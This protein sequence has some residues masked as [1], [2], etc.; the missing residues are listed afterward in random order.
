M[1]GTHVIPLAVVAAILAWPASTTLLGSTVS[2]PADDPVASLASTDARAPAICR[3]L[4]RQGVAVVGW[5]PGDHRPPWL[6][7]RRRHSHRPA[8]ARRARVLDGPPLRIGEAV[9]VSRPWRS[10]RTQLTVVAAAGSLLGYARYR[11]PARSGVSGTLRVL[12]RNGRPSPSLTVGG[13]R[14]PPVVRRWAREPAA[15]PTPAPTPTAT[16]TPVPTPTPPPAASG[17]SVVTECDTT[18][19]SDASDAAQF[20]RLWHDERNGPGWTGGD[21]AFSVRLDDGRIAWIFGDSFIG[22]VQPDGRRSPDWHLVRNTLVVQDGGCL[23]TAIGGT[24]QTPTALIRPSDP[25][26]W[27]WP[28]T[29]TAD[30]DLLHLLMQRVVRTGASSWD[31]AILG[32]D[33][34]DLDLRSFTVAAVRS[35]PVDG[36]VLWGSSVL[37]AGDATYMYG[38]ENTPYDARLYLA[39]V[40][41]RALAGPWQFYRGGERPWSAEARDAAPLLAA[42]ADRS[43]PP[44]PLTGMP[45]SV[46]AFTEPAGGEPEGTEPAGVVL[47]NQAPVFGT[48]VTFRRAPAPQGPFGAPILV[49]DAAP[50]PGSPEAFTYGARVHPQL[51]ADGLQL[52]SWNVNSFGDLLADASLYRPRFSAVPWPPRD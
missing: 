17:P 19:P 37:E 52:L 3:A 31:F 5:E 21:G 25:E 29:A 48:A 35:L 1:R 7:A 26:A 12:H 22:G 51:A 41:D 39:R 20:D 43:A 32:I 6:V 34:V 24:A 9:R 8:G 30:G 27:Y 33:L 18:A 15:I 36:S 46:T 10:A 13:R 38:V 49:A 42:P 44:A 14:V 45:A 47:V 11:L 4:M 23:S 50:P 2:A 28:Q 16:P 40:D